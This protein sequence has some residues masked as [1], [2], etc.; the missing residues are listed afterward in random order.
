MTRQIVKWL[1]I[2]PLVLCAR[3]NPFA[4]VVPT[5]GDKPEIT[6]PTKPDAAQKAPVRSKRIN[7]SVGSFLLDGKSMQIET[8]DTLIKHFSLAKPQKIVMDFQGYADFATKRLATQNPDFT[9]LTIGV[10]D[11]YYRVV[12]TVPQM[13]SYHITQ[14]RFGYRLTLEP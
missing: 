11:G 1:T 5:A 14:E 2:I 12:V 8:K 9:G 4:S 3:E 6:K 10:H 7:T 13:K